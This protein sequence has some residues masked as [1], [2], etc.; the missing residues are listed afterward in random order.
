MDK[1]TQRILEA[2][3]K[4]GGQEWEKL[5]ALRARCYNLEGALKAC[6]AHFEREPTEPDHRQLI[7]ITRQALEELHL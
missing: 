3:Q 7:Q 4:P 5:A 1:D 2:Y 6:L